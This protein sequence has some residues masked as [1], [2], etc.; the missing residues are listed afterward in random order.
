MC[1]SKKKPSLAKA[2]R[3]KQNPQGRN[4]RDQAMVFFYKNLELFRTGEP[5]LNI[6][7]KRAGY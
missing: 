2:Q 5:L 6:V 4:F 1:G 7:D 3:R